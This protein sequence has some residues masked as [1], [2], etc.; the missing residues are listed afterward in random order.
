MENSDKSTCSTFEENFLITNPKNNTLIQKYKVISIPR[1]MII[2]AKGVV[3]NQNA[4]RPSDPRLIKV[5]NELLKSNAI[6]L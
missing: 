5:F 2:D 1:Y 6:P 4:P 3:I